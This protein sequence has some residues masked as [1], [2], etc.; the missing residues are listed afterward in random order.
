VIAIPANEFQR[1]IIEARVPG[2][3]G[4]GISVAQSVSTNATEV[5]TVYN[6][7]TCCENLQGALVTADNPAVPGETVYVFAT[8]LGPTTPP[9]QSSGKIYTGGEFNPPAVPVDSILAG[10]VSANILSASLVPG[11]VGVYAVEFQLSSAQ[12]TD[13]LTQLTIAQQAFVSNVV[14]FAVG[15]EPAILATATGAGR[16]ARNQRKPG[17][18]GARR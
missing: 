18:R 10:G 15:A 9:D 11:L 2:P 13:S 1:I 17:L 16:P 5:I 4:E 14:T 8:G 6:P 3:A 7:I 12:P